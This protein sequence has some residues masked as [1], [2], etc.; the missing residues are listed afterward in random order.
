M[1]KDTRTQKQRNS[2]ANR[3]FKNHV[4][5]SKRKKSKILK[6][7]RQIELKK[8]QEQKFLR[9]MMRLQGYQV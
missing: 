3:K 9:H 6:K 4:K 1:K 2:E 5:E 8:E 7:L